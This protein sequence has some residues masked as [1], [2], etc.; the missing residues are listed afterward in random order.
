MKQHPRNIMDR[1][2]KYLPHEV[3]NADRD[4]GK[5]LESLATTHIRLQ[6][7]EANG[8][9]R[10]QKA[11]ARDMARCEERLTRLAATL[12]GGPWVV[13]LQG[14][15]GGLCVVLALRDDREAGE[16]GGGWYI[17]NPPRN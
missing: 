8:I 16:G 7:E 10:D 14:R 11:H 2:A 13:E 17:G 12:K 15:G 3:S 1:I 4:I 6:T 9:R 5:R